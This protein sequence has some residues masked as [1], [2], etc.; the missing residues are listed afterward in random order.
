MKKTKGFHKKHS[1]EQRILFNFFCPSHI[2]YLNIISLRK[3]QKNKFFC[4]LFLIFNEK[5]AAILLHFHNR[6][7]LTETKIHLCQFSY[8]LRNFSPIRNNH[9]SQIAVNIKEYFEFN[10]KLINWCGKSDG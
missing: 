8:E 2:P 7:L 10:I 5:L 9:N 1:T 6:S 4:L 3:P